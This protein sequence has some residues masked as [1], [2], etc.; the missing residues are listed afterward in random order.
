MPDISGPFAAWRLVELH[1][2]QV[3]QA[4]LHPGVPADDPALSEWLARWPGRRYVQS[5]GDGVEITLTRRARVRTRER[6]WLHALLLVL[7]LA[8]ATVAGCLLV[9]GDPMGWA[10][11]AGHAIPVPARYDLRS[12][13]PGL[14]FSLPLLCI[15]GAHEAGHWALA[16]RHGMDVSPP[17]FL[18]APPLLSPIG[19]FG[20]FIRIRSPLINRAALLDMGAAGPLAGFVLAVPVYLAGLMMSQPLAQRFSGASLAVMTG[21]G[22]LPL[23]ESILLHVLRAAT[24]MGHAPLVLLHPLAAAGWFGLF[25]TALN[26]FPISQLDGGHVVY[27]LS[28]RAHRVASR[29]TLALLLGMGWLY[30]GWWFWAGLVLMIGRGKLAHPPVFDPGFRLDARRRAVA[31]ACLVIF[32]IA[33]VPIPFVL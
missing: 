33:W 2:Q 30:T 14:W 24:P 9:P 11:S 29:A 20:A 23:G 17:W 25:F 22:A 32:V 7:T 19:T 21:D 8:T 1:D 15:L 27:S 12:V 3:L 6:W 16:R 4:R 31:W 26:L 10:E 18:P 13:A 28:P 5:G